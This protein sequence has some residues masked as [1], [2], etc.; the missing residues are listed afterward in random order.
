MCMTYIN[1]ARSFRTCDLSSLTIG[2][3]S[4]AWEVSKWKIALASRLCEHPGHYSFLEG[5]AGKDPA[6]LASPKSP[7]PWPATFIGMSLFLAWVGLLVEGMDL[8]LEHFS[9]ALAMTFFWGGEPWLR[10]FSTL[11]Q[12]F[13]PPARLLSLP[14]TPRFIRWQEPSIQG[15]LAVRRLSLLAL[16]VIALT[17]S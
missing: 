3:Q 4:F 1:N 6:P 17:I 2:R 13:P 11:T 7:P 12:Y 14:L 16:P 15:S 8:R 10:H 5:G 9:G